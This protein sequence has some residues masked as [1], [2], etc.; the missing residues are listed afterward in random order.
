MTSIRMLSV[1]FAAGLAA[2]AATG[3]VLAQDDGGNAS[4]SMMDQRPGGGMMDQKSGGGMMDQKSGGGMMD[5]RSP[6]AA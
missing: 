2:F 5:G 6:A 1:A 4:G 3:A